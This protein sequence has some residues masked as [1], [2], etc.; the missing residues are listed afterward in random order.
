M[1]PHE[2][3]RSHDRYTGIPVVDPTFQCL[4]SLASVL[5]PCR[6]CDTVGKCHLT[7]FDSPSAKHCR[8]S[9][10]L[11][12]D[13]NC[14]LDSSSEASHG[15]HSSF[16]EASAILF[17]NSRLPQSFPEFALQIILLQPL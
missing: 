1:V 5:P 2:R 14:R 3:G 13:H 6:D 9:F 15:L 10:S 7:D 8:S 16:E 17:Q 12:W 11:A 4:W